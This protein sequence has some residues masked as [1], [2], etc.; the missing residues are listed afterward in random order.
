MRRAKET[1]KSYTARVEAYSADITADMIDREAVKKAITAVM[2]EAVQ[3]ACT[4][5][6][7]FTTPADGGEEE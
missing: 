4:Y 7:D 6:A 1:V 3:W 2:E 5:E